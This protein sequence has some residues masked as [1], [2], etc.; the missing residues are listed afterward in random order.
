MLSL[1][2]IK[3][4]VFIVKLRGIILA[5]IRLCIRAGIL[6]FVLRK[7]GP[8]GRI[9]VVSRQRRRV[10]STVSGGVN[11]KV[12]FLR[13]R[14]CC[15]GDRGGIVLVIIGERRLVPLG[16]VIA[17][18]S[19]G[20]FFAVDRT[21]DIVKRNFSCLVS[22]RRCRR[23]VGSFVSRRSRRRWDGSAAG[24]GNGK[25]MGVSLSFFFIE[26]L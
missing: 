11:H 9:L 26:V 23:G 4:S 6:S 21:R 1:F 22:S 14:N 17:T 25:P 3:P 2:I 15:S 7:F 12:A 13:N 18:V 19:P 20:T 16:H 5:I 10:T 8:G 24:G